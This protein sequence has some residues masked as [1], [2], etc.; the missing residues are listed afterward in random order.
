MLFKEFYLLF[1][2][3]LLSH[4]N[5]IYFYSLLLFVYVWVRTKNSNSQSHKLGCLSVFVFFFFF[6][7]SSF[8]SNHRTQHSFQL[9]HF[10]KILNPNLNY[11]DIP[12]YF[13]CF[14]LSVKNATR[15]F[16]QQ[17]SSCKFVCFCPH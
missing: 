12:P 5:R 17:I 10:K 4:L 15:T 9:H 6:G 13:F 14:T 2:V 8:I 11:C 3:F 16:F 7:L 1:I